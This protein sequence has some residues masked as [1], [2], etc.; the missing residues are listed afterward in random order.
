MKI[1]FQQPVSL[2]AKVLVVH[3]DVKLCVR[4]VVFVR[5]GRHLTSDF[6]GKTYQSLPDADFEALSKCMTMLASSKKVHC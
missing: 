1:A 6:Y 3:T 4:V 2:S 5:L